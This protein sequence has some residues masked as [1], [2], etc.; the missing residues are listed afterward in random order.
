MLAVLSKGALGEKH[1]SSEA[2]KVGTHWLKLIGNPKLTVPAPWS[3]ELIHR[4]VKT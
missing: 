2:K 4:A 1:K 3:H